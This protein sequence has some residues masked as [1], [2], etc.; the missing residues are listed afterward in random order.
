MSVGL[1][2]SNQ[3]KDWEVSILRVCYHLGN[4]KKYKVR[5]KSKKIED[6]KFLIKWLVEDLTRLN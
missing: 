2:H 5:V 6:G 3:S 1:S 4:V